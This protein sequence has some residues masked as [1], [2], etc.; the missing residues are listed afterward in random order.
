MT[1]QDVIVI[2]AGVLGLCTA[3]E[4]G[5][6]GHAVTVLDR[7]GPN[8]SSV[9][10][11]MIAPALE[12]LA[13]DLS[14]DQA[15]FLKSARDLW[16]PFADRHGLALH[17]EGAEWR[18]PDPDAAI[19]RLRVLGFAAKRLSTGL[20]TP[21]DWRVEVAGIMARLPHSPGVTAEI[22]TVVGI[23]QD[24]EGWRARASDGR[25]WS[26]RMIVVATGVAASLPGLPPSVTVLVEGIEPIRGQLV[27]VA[28]AAPV[29]VLRAPGL[30]AVPGAGGVLF[31]ATME[32]GS[33]DLSP[34]PETMR[35]QVEAGLGLLETGGQALEPRVG[36][37]GATPDGLPM[38]GPSGVAGLHLALAPRR[39]GW[40]LG[41][42]V[43]RTV[44]DG[45][46]GVV[47]APQAAA[48]DP[49]RFL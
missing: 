36:V 35:A 21:D 6:R 29:R 9:A 46:E 37:R 2:G 34:D 45:I 38:A 1:S 32:A 30:Y 8:A 10:A 3:A 31:G 40:L 41:P 39:N 43:A 49:L 12:S 23:E 19:A 17:L 42:L 15:A 7:G 16:P 24:G 20:L 27:A 4:L 48:L 18:G 22:A 5:A 26:A 28:C 44:A 11:G 33:R 47:P 13:E 25:S 14:P